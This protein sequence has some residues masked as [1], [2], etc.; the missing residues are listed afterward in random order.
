MLI[1]NNIFW[2]DKYFFLSEKKL[3]VIFKKYIYVH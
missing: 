3:A 2:T 1:I